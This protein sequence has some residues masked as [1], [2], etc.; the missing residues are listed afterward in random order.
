MA[1][2]WASSLRAPMELNLYRFSDDPVHACEPLGQD[3][4]V[5]LNDGRRPR[6]SVSATVELS[7]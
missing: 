5:L 3:A 7:G 1:C 6:L 2:S 4:G